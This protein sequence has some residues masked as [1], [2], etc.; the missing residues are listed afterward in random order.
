MR[1][2]R[3]PASLLLGP[4][5]LEQTEVS[6]KTPQTAPATPLPPHHGSGLPISGSHNIFSH[7]LLPPQEKELKQ[8]FLPAF[9]P[10][11]SVDAFLRVPGA[12]GKAA[13]F[14]GNLL[15]Y[16]CS[17]TIPAVTIFLFQHLFH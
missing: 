8:S 13:G 14:H 2:G 9:I 6:E 10:V 3:G 15:Y 17:L 5:L 7:W 4:G 12:G 11:A 16:N 1:L